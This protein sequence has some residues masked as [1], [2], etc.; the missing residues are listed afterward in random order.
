MEALLARVKKS[1]VPTDA[2]VVKLALRETDRA[3][4]RDFTPITG[5]PLLAAVGLAAIG[6]LAVITAPL[7]IVMGLRRRPSA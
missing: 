1:L 7:R 3:A 5:G 2:E 6:L 4:Y